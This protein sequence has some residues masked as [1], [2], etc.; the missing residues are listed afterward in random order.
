MPLLFALNTAKGKLHDEG[1]F[2]RFFQQTV[3]EFVQN[4][5]GTA[6]NGLCLSLQNQSVSIRVHPWFKNLRQREVVEVAVLESR[7]EVEFDRFG[8]E[9]RHLVG[10]RAVEHGEVGPAERRVADGGDLVYGETR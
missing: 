6:D 9:V 8:V 7:V 2:V 10:Q 3:P 4:F 5:E 1:V